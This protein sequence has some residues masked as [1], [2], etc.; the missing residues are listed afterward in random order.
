[1]STS[2]MSDMDILN[3]MFQ[4]EV[5]VQKEQDA[6]SKKWNVILREPN[7]QDSK[8]T[9]NNI[10]SDA[11]IVKAESFFAVIVENNSLTKRPFFVGDRGECKRADFIMISEKEKVA[12]FIEMKRDK[13][14][15][16]GVI[17]QLAGAAC[18]FAYCQKIG[19]LFWEKQDFLKGYTHL[20]I[21]VGHTSISK[22]PVEIKPKKD[23]HGIPRRH[24][25]PNDFKIIN[26]P[27]NLQYSQLVD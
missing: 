8:M 1:M 26:R 19:E 3:E 14:G 20:Y 4:P 23:I 18:L 15:G 17:K 7:M 13:A 9:V 21:G 6:H 27:G 22:K 16:V 5:R 11:V 24:N 12:I 25:K 2:V 10:P